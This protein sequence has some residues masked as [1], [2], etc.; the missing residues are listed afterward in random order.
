MVKKQNKEKISL[1][2]INSGD[3]EYYL[4][5][6]NIYIDMSMRTLKKFS[7]KNLDKQ[8]EKYAEKKYQEIMSSNSNFD[9]ISGYDA[10]EHAKSYSYS[11]ADD[12]IFLRKITFESVLSNIYHLWEK[13]IKEFFIRSFNFRYDYHPFEETVNKMHFEEFSQMFLGKIDRY[14]LDEIKTLS[15]I[16][17]VAKHGGGGSLTKLIEKRPDIFQVSPEIEKITNIKLRGYDNLNIEETDIKRYSK[18][19]NDFWINFP[20][21]LVLEIFV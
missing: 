14:L 4:S 1:I 3:S 12:L 9:D 11:K 5:F 20:K 17:N 6:H 7:W 18:I 19:I 13:Q 16:A 8:A 15:L 10:Y 2:C 21:E